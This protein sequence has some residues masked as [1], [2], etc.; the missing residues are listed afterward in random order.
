MSPAFCFLAATALA[1]TTPGGGS[2]PTYSLLTLSSGHTFRVLNSGPMLDGKGRRLALAISYLSPA[3]TLQQLEAS[4][5]ELFEYLRP[6]A[7]QQ[8][9]KD[10]VVIAKVGSGPEEADYEMLYERQG[11]GEWKVAR[12]PRRPLPEP[13]ADPEA[14]ERDLAAERAAEAAPGAWL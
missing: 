11:F 4:A 7:E 3:R 14:D 1:S 2:R 5:D 10:V 9:D 8:D 6:H 12:G 13:A